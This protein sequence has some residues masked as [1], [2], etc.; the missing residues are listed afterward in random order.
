MRESLGAA[1][2][3]SGNAPEAEKVFRED[4]SRNPLNPRS[5]FGLWKALEAEK[6]TAEADKTRLLFEAN[7]KGNPKQLRIEDF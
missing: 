3:R 2:L 6:K 7:W 5:L 4:L 1:L